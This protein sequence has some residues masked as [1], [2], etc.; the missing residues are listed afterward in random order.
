LC[1]R[2]E[3]PGGKLGVVAELVEHL[4]RKKIKAVS[5][6]WTHGDKTP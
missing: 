6:T 3:S 5:L 1:L 2:H 4:I